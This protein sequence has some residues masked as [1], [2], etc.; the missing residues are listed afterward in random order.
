[1]KINWIRSYRYMVHVTLTV[2]DWVTLRY[3]LFAY[4]SVSVKCRNKVTFI[5]IHT[6]TYI[7]PLQGITHK[8]SYRFSFF[9]FTI[10][11]TIYA[12]VTSGIVFEFFFSLYIT[13]TLLNNYFRIQLNPIT[14]FEFFSTFMHQQ[15]V[16]VCV[17]FCFSQ[18]KWR[19]Q[20]R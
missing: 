17:C 15:N 1:M 9:F 13:P 4:S 20:L 11:N 12:S 8:Y 19:S 18:L 7:N 16:Y 3:K 10:R 5:A 14:R 2:S 6:C